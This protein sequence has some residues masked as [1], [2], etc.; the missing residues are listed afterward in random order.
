MFRMGK[1]ALK[2]GVIVVLAGLPC[3]AAMAKLA[4]VR[5][6]STEAFNAGDSLAH[7]TGMLPISGAYQSSRPA[8][9][10]AITGKYGRGY[11]NGAHHRG[12][13]GGW[14]AGKSWF[15]HHS[16]FNG[17]PHRQ[18]S[19]PLGP[20]ASQ[21]AGAPAAPTPAATHGKP[22]QRGDIS[23]SPRAGVT[24]PDKQY[25]ALIRA[26]SP[27]ALKLR[28]RVRHVQRPHKSQFKAVSASHVRW[29]NSTGRRNTAMAPY[30]RRY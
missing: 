26:T 18:K 19:T 24:L 2:V 15:G 10:G 6:L 21:T 23:A 28:P 8:A 14:F 5:H 13:H 4:A 17:R 30:V 3:S 25:R 20:A 16:W 22:S 27:V 1:L 12:H 11:R 29:S 7:K 9:S